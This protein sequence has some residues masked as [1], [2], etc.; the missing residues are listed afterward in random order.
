MAQGRGNRHGLKI[1]IKTHFQNSLIVL[2]HAADRL[3]VG[4]VPKVAELAQ[5]KLQS[6]RCAVTPTLAVWLGLLSRLRL[7]CP[8]PSTSQYAHALRISIS[9]KPGA[10]EE[11]QR[12][13]VSHTSA[14]ANAC[15]LTHSHFCAK[16]TTQA[17]E[18]WR[19]D[20]AACTAEKHDGHG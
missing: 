11:V 16:T 20:E 2:D 8:S 7:T 9:C 10:A 13:R 1:K 15:A 5:I 4:R 17:P 12:P 14:E 18:F 3:A 6:R 19:L